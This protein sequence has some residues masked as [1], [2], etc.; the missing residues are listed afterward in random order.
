VRGYIYIYI[1]GERE[2]K[3][4]RGREKKREEERRRERKR[5]EE[6]RRERKRKEERKRR[7]EKTEKEGVVYL[8][9]IN[10]RRLLFELIYMSSQ[11]VHNG[12]WCTMSNGGTPELQ[13][14]QDDL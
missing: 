5:K 10:I 13:L 11:E 4:K 12:C 14:L 6:R 3:K 7:N 1:E 2:K 8:L 9:H